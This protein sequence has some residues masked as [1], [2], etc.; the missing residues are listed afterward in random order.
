MRRKCQIGQEMISC[1]NNF[2]NNALPV[3]PQAALH[4][5][6]LSSLKITETSRSVH[7][8]ARREAV[9]GP[10]LPDIVKHSGEPAQGHG[11][12]TALVFRRR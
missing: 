5:F 4:E 9:N 12:M 1:K 3:Y 7:K 10:V 2:K 6:R 11:A 8:A